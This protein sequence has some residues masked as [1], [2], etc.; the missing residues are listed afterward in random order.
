MIKGVL[1][2][3]IIIKQMFP[4]RFVNFIEKNKRKRESRIGTL[5]I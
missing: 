2:Y 3:L 4:F 1:V 5:G